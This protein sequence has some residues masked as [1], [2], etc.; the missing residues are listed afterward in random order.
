MAPYTGPDRV[1]LSSWKE[2]AVHLGRDVRT[3]LRWHKDR[4]LPVH[5]LPGGHGRSVFAYVDELDAW[6]TGTSRLAEPTEASKPRRRRRPLQW[7]AVGVAA[8]LL[9][10]VASLGR[11][12]APLATVAV[13]GNRLVAVDERQH[14]RWSLSFP[15]GSQLMSTSSKSVLMSDIDADGR[16]DILAAIRLQRPDGSTANPLYSLS[17]AGAV[18]WTIEFGDHLGF[19]SGEYA[20]PWFVEDLVVVP[21]GA[22]RRVAVAVVHGVWWPSMVV[23]L[24]ANGRMSRPF[25][26]SGWITDL[27]VTRDGK[28]LLAAGVSNARDAGALAVLDA[29]APEGHSPEDPG[30]PYECLKCEQGLP[31]KYFV[32]PRS[33]L[34]LAAGR[35]LLE[36]G[37]DVQTDGTI[38][39]RTPQNP[40]NG[41]AEVIYEFAPDLT[42]RRATFSDVYWDWHRRMEA[43]GLIHH[44]A[45]DCP[46]RQGIIVQE[47]TS[48]HGWQRTVAA[49]ATAR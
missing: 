4:G 43:E 49:F 7:T 13:R 12:R 1:R 41:A 31:L 20:P 47:W 8:C 6:A 27:N 21:H 2:I 24:D 44:R 48:A 23:L 3:V 28:Y 30:S 5:R 35:A 33:E 26:N 42:L 29:A 17:D 16:P 22:A 38:L 15:A 39:L 19:R 46:E 32:L 40:A 37:L 25:V 14:E 18:K 45:D 9:V 36:Q 34:S 10:A 11:A